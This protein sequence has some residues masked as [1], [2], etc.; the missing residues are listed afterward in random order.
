MQQRQRRQKAGGIRCTG[1]W[2]LPAMNLQ[3][4]AR[5]FGFVVSP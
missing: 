2:L 4:F 1:G 5:V 3:N